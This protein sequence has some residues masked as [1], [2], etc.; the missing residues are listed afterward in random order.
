MKKSVEGGVLIKHKKV[1]IYIP[2]ITLLKISIEEMLMSYEF[3]TPLGGRGC[4]GIE[5]IFLIE[6]DQFYKSGCW[7]CIVGLFNTWE[8]IISEVLNKLSNTGY[9]KEDREWITREYY[10]RE[11]SSYGRT[12][13]GVDGW[14]VPII[15]YLE[16]GCKKVRVV[17]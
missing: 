9:S 8:Q 14:H 15:S 10:A 7:L 11:L 16:Q 4:Y 13:G 17:W 1:K 12:S 2:I 6:L 3:S 5:L